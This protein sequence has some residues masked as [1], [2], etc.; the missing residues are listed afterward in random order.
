MPVI[1]SIPGMEMVVMC[2]ADIPRE[3]TH[4]VG[5]P[6]AD[7]RKVDARREDMLRRVGDMRFC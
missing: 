7:I 6:R 3:G 4:K 5:I 1:P 2:R